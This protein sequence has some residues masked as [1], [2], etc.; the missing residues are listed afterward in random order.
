MVV[1]QHSRVGCWL[2]GLILSA[3]AVAES[4][5]A[6]AMGEADQSLEHE[7]LDQNPRLPL[8]PPNQGSLC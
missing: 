8:L 4:S 6:T 5:E 7:Q 1:G 2:C 3:I